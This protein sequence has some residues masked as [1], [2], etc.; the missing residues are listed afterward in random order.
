VDLM[1]YNGG[2]T[3]AVHGPAE[4]ELVVDAFAGAFRALRDADLVAT[5]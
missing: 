3:S 1:A 4:L 5:C 2:V